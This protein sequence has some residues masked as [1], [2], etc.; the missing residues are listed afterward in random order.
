M[1]GQAER[2]VGISRVSDVLSLVQRFRDC[3]KTPFVF[4]VQGI[5]VNVSISE[6]S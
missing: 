6:S 2:L 1:K 3:V 5:K 4:N